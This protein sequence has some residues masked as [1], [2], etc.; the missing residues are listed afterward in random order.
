MNHAVE[1]TLYLIHGLQKIISYRESDKHFM[2]ELLTCANIFYGRILLP[3]SILIQ[4]TPSTIQ[5]KSTMEQSFFHQVL[6]YGWC[7]GRC[8]TAGC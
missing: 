6:C 1:H 7:Q 2:E 8:A 4:H 5:S 3:S